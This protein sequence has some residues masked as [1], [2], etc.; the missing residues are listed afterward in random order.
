MNS[1][2]KLPNV[3]LGGNDRVIFAKRSFSSRFVKSVYLFFS[4]QHKSDD[5]PR[6]IRSVYSLKIKSCSPYDKNRSQL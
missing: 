2:L 4:C 1:L 5:K 3:F 6:Q